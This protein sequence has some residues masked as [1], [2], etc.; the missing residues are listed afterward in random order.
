MDER[1]LASTLCAPWIESLRESEARYRIISEL[2]SDYAYAF[3]VT[4]EG[5]LQCEWVT[6]AFERITGYTPEMLMRLGGYDKLI[7][8]E[9]LPISQRRT[10]ALLQGEADTSE[11]RIVT[12]DGQVRWVRDSVRPEMDSSGRVV[13]VYGAAQD[14]TERRVAEEKL[15]KSEACLRRSEER[16]RRLTQRV[17]A[18][19]EEERARISRKI[20]DELGQ[21]LTALRFDVH[22]LKARLTRASPEVK[23]KLEA[24]ITHI[25][26]AIRQVQQLASELRPQLLDDLGLPAA[27]EWSVKQFAD[28]T[29]LEYDLAIEPE[30]LSI[31]PTCATDLYRILQEAL[32]NVA[33]H[34]QATRVEVRLVR[35]TDGVTLSVRD[36]GRG[37]TLQEVKNP[38]ALGIIGMRERAQRW[39]GRFEISGEPGKGTVVSVHIPL[40]GEAG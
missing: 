27:V 9:D 36:N 28:R 34:A 32:T 16:L 18:L 4:P 29:G 15:R 7:H 20:H 35:E 11:F 12:R 17:D 14:I 21:T 6:D 30:D 38:N 31:P 37:V 13:R 39:G 5:A 25:D 10:L 33:R 19:L 24:M 26:E 2:M 1:D 23:A 22:W 3:R 8:P 40:R